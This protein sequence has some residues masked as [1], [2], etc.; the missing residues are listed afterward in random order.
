MGFGVNCGK[1]EP[2]P[3]NGKGQLPKG[4]RGYVTATPKDKNNIDVPAK[5]HGPNITWELVYGDSVVSVE[6]PTF[7][8]DFNKDLVPVSIGDFGLCATVKG[9]TGC[10]HGHV[11]PR[12]GHY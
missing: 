3:N 9:V 4:C 7:P 1:G 8:S 10:L 11:I 6:D 5:I 2:H 12:S